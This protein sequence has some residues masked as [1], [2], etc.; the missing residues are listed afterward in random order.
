MIS[1]KNPLYVLSRW[2]V[3]VGYENGMNVGSRTLHVNPGIDCK[4]DD[5]YGYN[6][7]LTIKENK[8]VKIAPP[9]YPSHVFFGDKAMS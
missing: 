1:V 8:N 5:N 4:D 9:M 6:K 2:L 3:H 7:K